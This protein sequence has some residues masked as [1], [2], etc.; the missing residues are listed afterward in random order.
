[1]EIIHK[2]LYTYKQYNSIII[3]FKNYKTKQKNNNNI[4]N[5]IENIKTKCFTKC[6]IQKQKKKKTKLLNTL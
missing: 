5:S 3:F 1:M 6:Y 4:I 2:L